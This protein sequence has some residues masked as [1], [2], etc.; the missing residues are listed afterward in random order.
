MDGCSNFIEVA[1]KWSNSQHQAHTHVRL[2]V[3]NDR[4]Y[5]GNG[6]SIASPLDV[7]VDRAARQLLAAIRKAKC[8]GIRA[9]FAHNFDEEGE[10][11]E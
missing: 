10:F 4:F 8:A 11:I 3:E 7:P 5:I 6:N 9:M 1:L 2:D